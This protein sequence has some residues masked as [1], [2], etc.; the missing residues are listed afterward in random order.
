MKNFLQRFIAS[1]LSLSI[2]LTMMPLAAFAQQGVLY[3]DINRSGFVD[4]NDVN[5]FKKYLAEYSIDIDTKA[6]DV[7]LDCSLDLRDLLL[8][9]KYI[10]GYD[11]V[12]GDNVIITFDTN[13]GTRVDPVML[14]NG[15]VLTDIMDEP[16][17]EKDGHIFIGWFMDD[18]SPFYA[19]EAITASMTIHAK[20]EPI[21]T[22]IY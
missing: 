6:A 20:F 3:G 21:D 10:A 14:C 16:V 15:A 4:Q 1:I 11:V 2:A 13:G 5:D 8:I 9:E 12:L 22:D 18:G 7:N 17:T 19:E